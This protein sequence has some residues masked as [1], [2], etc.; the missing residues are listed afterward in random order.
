MGRSSNVRRYIYIY[1]NIYFPIPKC[2]IPLTSF[3]SIQTPQPFSHRY[4]QTPFPFALFFPLC[5][6]SSCSKMQSIYLMFLLCC[7]AARGAN[8]IPSPWDY[9]EGADITQLDDMSKLLQ[10]LKN[11]K[12]AYRLNSEFYWN[13]D[14]VDSV[15]GGGEA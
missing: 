13:Y 6:F 15:S 4:I 7:L 12:I 3:Y 1:S 5:R 10:H 14:L 11:P 9:R 8:Y 2:L